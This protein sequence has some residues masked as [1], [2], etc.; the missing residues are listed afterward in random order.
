MAT[1]N[2]PRPPAQQRPG[3]A[4]AAFLAIGIGVGTAMGVA[5][6]NIGL[7]IGIGLAIGIALGLAVDA[8]QK[9][10]SGPDDREPS[11]EEHP[12]PPVK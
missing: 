11:D 6:H 1:S 7:G 9:K 4:F 12:D 8:S 5:L 10:G 3:G 2:E